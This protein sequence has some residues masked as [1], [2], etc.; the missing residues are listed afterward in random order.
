MLR[1]RGFRFILFVIVFAG[2]SAPFAPAAE[3]A[4]EEY[5]PISAVD[6][7]IPSDQLRILLTPLTKDELSAEADAWMEHVKE[8]VREISSAEIAVKFK[9]QQIDAA[10]QTA[11]AV[12]KAKK[13]T[14][15]GDAAPDGDAEAQADAVVEQ[16]EAVASGEAE[17]SEAV[18]A[19]AAEAEQ[20][21][22][23]KLA[24]QQADPAASAAA[25]QQ[26]ESGDAL[27]VAAQKV[28][29]AAEEQ[30]QVKTVLLDHLTELRD[31]RTALI[32][33]M[34]VVLDEIDRKGGETDEYRDYLVAVSGIRVESDDLE[35]LW[36]T[37]YGWLTS[38]QG[39]IRWGLNILQFVGIIVAFLFAGRI[40]EKAT[41]RAMRVSRGTSNLMREFVSKSV[42]R[43][44][45]ALG[46]I[47]GLSALEINVGPV[48]AVIGAAG[49]VIAF[50]LQDTLG[51]FASGIM[52][53]VYRP[54]DVGDVVDVAD[55]S[56]TVA[57]LNIV[58]TTIKTFDNKIMIVPNNSVWQNV[59]TNATGSTTRR[60]DLV[61]G[62]GYQ[63]D[64]DAA[65]RVLEE[66]VQ[67]H[68]KTLDNPAPTICVNELGDS[69]VNFI[70]RPWVK[71]AD[72][73]P[74]YWDLTRTVKKRFDEEGISIPFPQRD[75]HVYNVNAPERAASE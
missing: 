1:N 16:A 40:A 64:I 48:L 37:V 46:L 4:D 42:R 72:Y 25:T 39:G 14:D 62:I 47:F 17:A 53:L 29:Q 44:M 66:V 70:C 18:A 22:R 75:V 10:K 60:V 7:A 65:Q 19:S 2:L 51:N 30:A 41:G 28:E 67:A 38:Q 55:V 33:R 8:K 21:A 69:S 43:V 61:F 31:E 56:G 36:A 52:I 3:T 13:A 63:D 24:E 11:K 59:I 54:F 74:V 57:A 5:T 26:P 68:P 27:E 45:I 15:G 32:D 23:E 71:T 35:S 50:A 73:W 49:F 20:R 12:D 9:N 6:P 58:S 34:R